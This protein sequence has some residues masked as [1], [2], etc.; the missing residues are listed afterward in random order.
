[1]NYSDY[2]LAKLA[3]EASEVSQA[4]IKAMLFGNTSGEYNNL[5]DLITEF[6][7]LLV[8]YELLV[9]ELENKGITSP[10]SEGQIAHVVSL[11]QI[12]LKKYYEEVK[13]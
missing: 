3:E 6:I 9:D 11:K 10:L 5:K 7:E 2:L 1:M 13:D 8:V 4:A 12:R